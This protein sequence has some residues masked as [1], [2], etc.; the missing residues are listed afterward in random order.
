MNANGFESD[1]AEAAHYARFDAL[2]RSNGFFEIVG[3]GM[4]GAKYILLRRPSRLLTK[5]ANQI[6]V[7]FMLQMAPLTF[8]A[9]NFPPRIR[10][11]KFDRL[12]AL[13]FVFRV[14]ER[15]GN[16]DLLTATDDI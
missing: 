1:A 9:E 16:F 7:N 4:D 14:A 6:S 8:W 3:Y 2:N 13:N 11:Q 15:V 10:G 12:H 5:S